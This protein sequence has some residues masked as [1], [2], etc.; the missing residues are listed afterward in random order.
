MGLPH[1]ASKS[2]TTVCFTRDASTLFLDA[3]VEAAW[4][5]KHTS[6]IAAS[7]YTP[8][9]SA[10][11]VKVMRQA[12][13][14]PTGV[15]TCKV[16]RRLPLLVASIELLTGAIVLKRTACSLHA[17]SGPFRRCWRAPSP[18]QARSDSSPPKPVRAHV[19][20]TEW[21]CPECGPLT[22][23]RTRIRG[24]TPGEPIIASRLE[25]GNILAECNGSVRGLPRGN[26][27]KTEPSRRASGEPEGYVPR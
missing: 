20:P 17:W 16:A 27:D 18:G 25:S 2:F 21:E 3:S 12:I 13:S 24:K 26:A 7:P 10:A 9:E 5:P 4:R 6:N 8:R 19:F 23:S 11:E 22:E 15:A 1:L 14:R